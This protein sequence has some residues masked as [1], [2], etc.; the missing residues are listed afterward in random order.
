LITRLL[1][2][3]AGGLMLLG[4]LYRVAM[5]TFPGLSD[6]ISVILIFLAVVWCA[7]GLFLMGGELLAKYSKSDDG[8][9]RI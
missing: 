9:K 8:D 2:V 6:G 3:L 7:V 5:R 1:S 4:A